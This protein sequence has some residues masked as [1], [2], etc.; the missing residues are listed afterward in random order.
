VQV[1][2]AAVRRWHDAGRN[3]VAGADYSSDQD[4]HNGFAGVC[5]TDLEI[6]KGYV[7]G[8]DGALGH[9]FVGVVDECAAAPDLVGVISA[10]MLLI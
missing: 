9:E 10:A 6:I 4:R 7:P 1:R 5:S 8:F 2:H 3:L